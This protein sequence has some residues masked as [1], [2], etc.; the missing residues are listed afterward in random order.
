MPSIEGITF[1]ATSHKLLSELIDQL[2]SVGDFAMYPL[3]NMNKPRGELR[4]A[5]HGPYPLHP[6]GRGVFVMIR[7][8]PAGATLIRRRRTVGGEVRT[9]LNAGNLSEMLKLIIS[10]R[11]QTKNR[12]KGSEKVDPNMPGTVQGGQFES[13]R[14]KH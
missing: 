9:K 2:K 8:N 14:R 13:N 3:P 12:I 1:D 10:W 6:N 4:L 7:P 11:E 5:H